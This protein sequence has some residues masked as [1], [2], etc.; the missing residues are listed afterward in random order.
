ME[1]TED[2]MDRRV[3]V[4]KPGDALF[5]KLETLEDRDL[6]SQLC[7]PW[8]VMTEELP[9]EEYLEGWRSKILELCKLAFLKE[10]F[11]FT[12]EYTLYLPE[13]ILSLFV[14]I[15]FTREFFDAWWVTEEAEYIQIPTS[16]A[17]T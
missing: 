8:V 5:E 3:Y 2:I 15:E 9:F 4:V 10:N 12:E 16:W 6:I 11:D 13:D 14:N 1:E 7:K 17:K